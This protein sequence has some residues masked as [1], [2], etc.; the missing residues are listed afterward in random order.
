MDAS[1]TAA[2]R[3]IR[4]RLIAASRHERRLRRELAQKRGLRTSFGSG[5]AWPSKTRGASSTLSTRSAGR[6]SF[7]M[8]WV[9][10]YVD[11]WTAMGRPGPGWSDDE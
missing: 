10:A 2:Q 11:Y 8:E 9:D 5:P 7:D 3:I 6:G 1:Y 4:R